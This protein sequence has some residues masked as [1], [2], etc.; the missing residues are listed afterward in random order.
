MAGAGA[1]TIYDVA[2]A[3]GVSPSTVS[4][5]LSRPDRVSVR[6]AEHV[7]RVAL[8]IGYLRSSA[9][10]AGA[11]QATGVVAMVVADVANPVF[12]GMFRG[13]ESAARQAGLT[14]LLS[15]SQESAQIERTVITRLRGV[16]EGIILTSSRQTD[17][18]IRRAAKTLPLVVLNRLVTKVPSVVADN[19]RG[20]KRAVEYLAGLGHTELTYLG[21]PEA[22]WADWIR[23]R[24]IREACYEL[25]L[26]ARRVG[27][28]APTIRGG[29]NAGAQWR[30][31]TTSAVMTYNDLL[32]IG[33]LRWAQA[34]GVGVPGEVS[35]IGC[36]NILEGALMTPR[37][38]TLA[39]PL[40]TLGST[41]V[42][43]LLATRR[44]D[45]S[46]RTVELPMRLIVRDSTGAAQSAARSR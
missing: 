12:H 34:A 20:M 7:R 41:A 3:A 44:D 19:I 36:D 40:S 11:D 14:L 9:H 38:T 28:C 29:E 24:G 16:A 37:L 31:H 5:A 13:A 6:T 32:A 15:E 1:P 22:S 18:E 10:S 45:A 39:S 26:R 21:G 33:F 4:R 25:E 27:P 30:R 35:V 8:E 2:G 42:N 23:W 46:A 17:A 43:H